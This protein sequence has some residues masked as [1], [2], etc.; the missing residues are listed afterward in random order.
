MI[1]LKGCGTALV[2]PLTS[3]NL[4]DLDAFS[5]LVR[6]QVDSGVNFLVPAGTTGESV[7]LNEE[8]YRT[9]VRTCVEAANGDVPVVAGAGN[10]NT[11][12]AIHLS[13]IAEEQGASA[14]LS[15]SPYYNKPTQEG[16]FRHFQKIEQALGIP[17]VLYNVPGRTG[18][19]VEAQT[20][21]RLSSL[22]GV[23]GIKEASSNLDQIMAILAQRTEGFSVLSGDDSVALPLTMLGGDGV[24][25]VVS[26]LIPA[27]MSQMI[28]LAR[29]DQIEKARS[30][31]FQFLNLMNLNFIESNPI[32]VKYALH[33][34]GRIE[35]VY[36]LPLCPLSHQYKKKMDQELEKVNLVA[37]DD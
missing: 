8:E 14:I 18:N 31:H 35:E 23:V 24:I 37:R 26:N 29:Q 25:S 2:T 6:W 10:N 21:L 22:E 30:L 9:V 4:V 33:R 32:P 19:N 20:T 3:S 34:M 5:A 12:H 13:R 16:L 28:E 11:E 1:E 36:R 17:V 15:V 27:Q 7:T